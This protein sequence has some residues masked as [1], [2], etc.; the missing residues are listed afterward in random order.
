MARSVRRALTGHSIFVPRLVHADTVRDRMARFAHVDRRPVDAVVERWRD[1]CLLVDGSLFFEG[2]DIWTEANA[3][4]LIERFNEDQLL[5]ERSFEE[6]LT[7]QLS[8]ASQDAKRLMAEIIA[9]Y[10]FFATHVGGARK[11]QLVAFRPG[12]DRRHVP[13]RQRC[14]PPG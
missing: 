10:F 8:P 9:A 5:D 13:R 7:T 2:E 6:K 11:R 3:Q 14:W 4:E 1:E 12:D